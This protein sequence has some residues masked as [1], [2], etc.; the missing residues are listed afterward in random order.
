MFMSN[1]EESAKKNGLIGVPLAIVCHATV[2]RER[3]QKIVLDETLDDA[4]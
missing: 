4:P 3:L 2:H 1:E